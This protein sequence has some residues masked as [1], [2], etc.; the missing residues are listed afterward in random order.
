MLGLPSLP[1]LYPYAAVAV[2]AG[3]LAAGGAWT[4]QGW[5]MG[6]QLGALKAEHADQALTAA[7]GALK[8]TEHYRENADAAVKKAESRM[9]Q[10]KRDADSVRAEL[11]GLRG[12]LAGVPGLIAS[13]SRAAVDQ[14]AAAA[15]VVFEQCTAR[16]SEVARDAD[17]HAADVATLI[18]AWPGGPAGSEK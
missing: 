16:Y 18:D 7:R 14:Y 1:S 8:M 12:E 17:G 4:V 9:A 13:A 2:V 3:A 6:E 11:D 15:T 5:R 10:N